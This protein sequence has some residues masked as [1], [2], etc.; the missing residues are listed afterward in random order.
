MK[1]L[2]S[3]VIP[4]YNENDTIPLL[5]KE[6]QRIL[7]TIE[8]RYAVE[9]IFV[10]DGSTDKSALTIATIAAKDSRIK[11]IEFSRNFGKELA[12]TAGITHAQGEAILMMDADLQ[13]PPELIPEFIAQWE[14]GAEV[15]IGV[16]K[17]TQNIPL[18][19]HLGSYLY[20]KISDAISR[21]RS[22]PNATD[23][24]L[25]NKNVTQEFL[26]FTETNRMTRGLID[27]LGF[28]SKVIL[29]DSP[30]RIHGTPA[31]S[32]SKLFTLALSSF[33]SNSL[34][35]L[36]LAG[37]LGVLVIFAFSIL[38][39]VIFF[40]RY[41]IMNPFGIDTSVIDLQMVFNGILHGVT[42]LCLGLIALY[43]GNIHTEIVRRPL[44]VIRKKTNIPD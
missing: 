37:Y 14:Q 4:F 9:C 5:Y 26:R 40:N 13:H 21:T 30:A 7:P 6:L 44:Y 1:P 11:C 34:F 16:R 38:G 43:I 42:L 17:T 39:G 12:L 10:N 22:I 3:L 35:P 23:F 32:Y 36:K 18:A 2:I 24:R 20:Y 29:F 19:K 33:V 27:W 8:T 31:Y 28:T 25:I 15:V 41:I